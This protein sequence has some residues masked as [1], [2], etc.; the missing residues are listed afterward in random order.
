[1][2]R[3]R[4]WI[5]YNFFAIAAFASLPTT[6][7]AQSYPTQPIKIVVATPPGGIADLVGRTVSQK[8]S[9]AGFASIVENRTGGAGAIGAQAVAKAPPD[10]Y[11]L[12]VGMHQTNAILPNIM[13]RLP[14]DGIRDFAPITNI[15]S[16][17]TVLVVNPTLPVK[18]VSELIAYAKANA[19]K[20]SYA[21]QG[22]GSAGHIIAEQFKSAA[23]LEIP[24]V[25]YRG[26]A[27][28]AQDLVAGHV[29]MMFDIVP[30]ARVQIAAGKMRGLAIGAAARS[31]V[32]P[33]IPTMS[34]AGFPD[35]EGSPWFGLLA[36]AG[37]P[38]E[39]VQWLNRET[40]KA[41]SSPAVRQPFEKQ[42]LTLTLGT[43]EDFGAFIAAENKKWGDIIRKS[44]IKMP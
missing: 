39:I 14:Y 17:A 21:S 25:P 11:T 3:A 8:F 24:H 43:P 40:H 32:L 35:I 23:G 16:S 13:A 20:L 19:G 15:L 38:K 12:F 31:P 1:M 18:S 36:P 41:F 7:V 26:A 4:K 5:I 30:L 6:M 9:E 10:G 2:R 27:P 28:A 42:G 22:N 44:G 34:E 37:T 29:A 33:D